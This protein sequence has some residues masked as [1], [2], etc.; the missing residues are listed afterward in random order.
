[1]KRAATRRS[2]SSGQALVEIAIL[3][4]AFL[5]ILVGMLEFGFVFQHNLTLEYASREGARTGA[6]LADGGSTNCPSPATDSDPYII[7]AVER[8]LE[9]PGSPIKGNISS[10][11]QIQ[12]YAA[13]AAGTPISAAKTNTWTYT[14]I[15]TGPSIDGG[16]TRLDFSR[17]GAQ[18]W[19]T[20]SRNNTSIPPD[21]IGVSVKYTYTL[22][23]P[24]SSIMKFFGPGGAGTFAMSDQSVMALNPT[25]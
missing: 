14:G 5:L 21:S 24:L 25:N 13:T 23:T 17:S 10:V 22:I 11:S 3:L 12:I 2:R 15:G 19:L 8:V 6:A 18:N 9:S 4:P 7:A 1:M 16:L 20:C